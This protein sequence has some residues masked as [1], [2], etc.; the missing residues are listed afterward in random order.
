M[1][2][3]YN[4]RLT[5]HSLVEPRMVKKIEFMDAVAASVGPPFACAVY[6]TS[7]AM[8]WTR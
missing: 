2:A 3:A 4:G 6:A 8:E 1:T 7:K 5:F